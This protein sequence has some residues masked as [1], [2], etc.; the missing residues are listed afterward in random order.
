VIKSA[1]LGTQAAI[2]AVKRGNVG[3]QEIRHLEGFGLKGVVP[4]RKQEKRFGMLF[5]IW[6][7]KATNLPAKRAQVEQESIESCL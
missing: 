2:L 7:L 1:Y 6:K 3:N 4:A 5:K